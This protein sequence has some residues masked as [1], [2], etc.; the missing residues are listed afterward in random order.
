MSETRITLSDMTITYCLPKL[1]V[2]TEIPEAVK[3][4]L[5]DRIEEAEAKV[6]QHMTEPRRTALKW[7]ASGGFEVVYLDEPEPL[8]CTC[9]ARAI[10]HRSNCPLA[11]T[12]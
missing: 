9:G 3:K 2:P 12:A 4:L 7:T 10:V 5:K 11:V 1:T 8:R 6:W